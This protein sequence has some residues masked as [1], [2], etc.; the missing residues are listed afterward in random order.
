MRPT[1]GRSM[2]LDNLEG[3]FA[4]LVLIG[5]LALALLPIDVDAPLRLARPHVP[6]RLAKWW[7]SRSDGSPAEPAPDSD[8]N[9]SWDDNPKN[10]RKH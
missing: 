10:K 9:Q 1:Y 8:H 3:A 4:L 6:G 2:T 5:M 7:R